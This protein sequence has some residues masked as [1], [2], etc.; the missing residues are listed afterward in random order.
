MTDVEGNLEHP[1][2][3]FIKSDNNLITVTRT[4]HMTIKQT[5]IRSLESLKRVTTNE[6]EQSNY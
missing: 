4:Y 5:V 1:P 6:K 2:P 3:P